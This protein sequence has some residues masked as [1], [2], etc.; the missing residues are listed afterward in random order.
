VFDTLEGLTRTHS[1]DELTASDNGVE[2]VLMGWVQRRRDHGGLIFVDLRDREGLTQVVFNPKINPDTHTKAG[3]L[4]DE[5]V[6]AVRGLVNLRPEDMVNPNLPT[7]EIEVLVE[8]LRFLNSSK[9][10]PFELEDYRVDISE[11]IRLKYR[12]LDLRRP[13]VMQNILF[14][15]RAAQVT[16]Q[17]LNGQ[18]FIEVETPI[19]TKSTPEGARD[20]LVPSRVHPGQFFALP[21]SPQ[22][23]KQLLMMAGLDRYYQLC[24]CFRDEDLRADRQP[25]FT[26]I[27]VEMAFITEADIMRVVEG[28]MVAL[29]RDLKGID[30]EPPFPRLTFQECL[31]RFGLDRPDTRFGLELKDI[32]DLVMDSEF[33]QFRE[34]VDQG[35]IVKALNGQGLAKLSRK[36]LDGLIDLAG[37]YGARGLAWVKVQENAWQSPLAKF[38]PEAAKAEVARRLKAQPGDLLLFVADTPQVACTAMG[39][40]RLHL[41]QREGLIPEEAYS[42]VWVTDFP[43]L[44]F[45]ND[46]GRFVAM[47][48]P[49]TAPKEEDVPFLLTDPGQVRARAYDLVLNGVEIGGGSIRINRRDLQQQVFEVLKISAAEAEEKFG[50]LLEALE[51]GAPPHGGVAFG[52]D[53]LVAILSGAR[54]IREVIAFPKTQKAACPVTRAPARVELE[55]LLELGL[56]LEE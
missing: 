34:V 42:L 44:E 1:C 5:Y 11:A 33:R 46:E 9:T 18:G 29:F 50:F 28:L 41:G 23:F 55:Q 35:G 10:P 45:D 53:R 54:S 6:I 52:F 8:E 56:R 26:Q 15:H 36:D 40:V 48:H 12:Y 31:D 39:M 19:L 43:L 7:G 27:D 30:L 2:V 32:T 17:F 21:Q 37:V 13:S 49:F 47:H 3:V 14:R 22:L 4:R 16:R 24:R 38:F 20:Y 51:F 25:E